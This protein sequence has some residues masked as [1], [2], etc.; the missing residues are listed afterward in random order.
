M[1]STNRLGKENRVN[2]IRI[3]VI[4]KSIFAVA[5]KVRKIKRERM[6]AERKC[7]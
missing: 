7:G 4:A 5:G 2:L 6:T 1:I 3:F